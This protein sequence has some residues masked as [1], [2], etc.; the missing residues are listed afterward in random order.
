MQLGFVHCAQLDELITTAKVRRARVRL[1]AYTLNIADTSSVCSLMDR[2]RPLQSSEEPEA[3]V[4]P[5]SPLPG[6]AQVLDLDTLSRTARLLEEARALVVNAGVDAAAR[7]AEIYRRNTVLEESVRE[8][9][10]LL[11]RTESQAAQ[12]ANLYV[13]TYQLHASLDESDVRA[14]VADIAVNLLGAES[15]TIWVRS[16]EG[17]LLP[18]PESSG[19]ATDPGRTDTYVGGDSLIDAAIDSS[20]PQFGLVDGSKHVAAVPFSTHGEVVGVLAIQCF[21]KQKQTISADDC[22]LLDVMGA[23][24]A[25]ALLAARSFGVARRKLKTYEGLLGFLKRETP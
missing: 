10:E 5:I 25:T 16:E 4:S 9:E 12:L 3:S 8:I 19:L 1:I 18:A 21:L 15:F 22:Q 11:I 13:A 6:A 20:T 23:H 2:T 14:A 24:A 7:N 17:Q